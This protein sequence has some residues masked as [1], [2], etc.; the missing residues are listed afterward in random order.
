MFFFCWPVEMN[1]LKALEDSQAS[2]VIVTHYDQINQTQIK[3][4]VDQT[5]KEIKIEIQT[6]K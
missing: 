6:K 4:M 3:E 2:K 5:G 1:I